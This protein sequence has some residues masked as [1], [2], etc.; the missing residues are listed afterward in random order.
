MPLE[1]R[2]TRNR[3][4]YCRR[5]S[6]CRSWA[7]GNGKRVETDFRDFLPNVRLRHR[8]PDLQHL[9]LV[10]RRDDRREINVVGDGVRFDGLI[11]P[12]RIKWFVQPPVQLRWR[13]AQ[14]WQ[15]DGRQLHINSKWIRS[16]HFAMIL[17]RFG[18]WAVAALASR[19]RA[20]ISSRYVSKV[21]VHGP[22]MPGHRR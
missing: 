6:R 1:R 12:V 9:A 5:S 4:T 11:G 20:V 19:S 10:R 14:R 21:A 8:Q 22:N 7:N 18:M 15:K 3:R 13:S 17:R 16:I 2:G